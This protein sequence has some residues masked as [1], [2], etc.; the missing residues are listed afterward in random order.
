MLVYIA[1]V[2]SKHEASHSKLPCGI[3]AELAARS[4]V[5]LAYSHL[6]G[7]EAST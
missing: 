7:H 1:M 2:V 3:G 6:C 5:A 4:R